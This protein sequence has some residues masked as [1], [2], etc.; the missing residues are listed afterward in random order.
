MK[1]IAITFV[2]IAM[3]FTTSASQAAEPGPREAK[4]KQECEPF[5]ESGYVKLGKDNAALKDKSGK[6]IV[7]PATKKQIDEQKLQCEK[8]KMR[9]QQE[10]LYLTNPDQPEPSPPPVDSITLIGPP[11]GTAYFDP[12]HTMFFG[13]LWNPV[14]GATHI[15]CIATN[16]SKCSLDPALADGKRSH[17]D[18][19]LDVV[20][21]NG[22]SVREVPAFCYTQ[23]QCVW[24]IMACREIAGGLSWDCSYP[25]ATATMP[26]FPTI[27]VMTQQGGGTNP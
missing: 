26:A 5:K 15:L 13:P 2:A 18:Y 21:L 9:S 14:P 11:D 6:T 27:R 23:G 3:L 12:S 19:Y 25:T 4:L 7:T 20:S 16:Q 17:A 1:S 8:Q 24:S 22:N 10:P